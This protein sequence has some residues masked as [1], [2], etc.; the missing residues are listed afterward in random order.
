MTPP[1]LILSIIT[2]IRELRPD[3]ECLPKAEA[4]MLYC[5]VLPA[6]EITIKTWMESLS[7]D[8]DT[9]TAARDKE[10]QAAVLNFIVKPP[11]RQSVWSPVHLIRSLNGLNYPP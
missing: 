4:Y 10:M 2:W 5:T 6:D 1:E 3:I 8:P 11:A 9:E 7:A